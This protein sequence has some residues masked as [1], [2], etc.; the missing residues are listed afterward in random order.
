MLN[1]SNPFNG[2]QAQYKSFTMQLN[3]TFNPLPAGYTG[4]NADNAKITYVASYLFGSAKDWFQPHV[5]ETTIPISFPTWTEFIAALGATF[6]DLDAYQIAFNSISTLKQQRDC[7]SYYATFMSLA[8]VLNI[9]QRTKISFFK[10][11]L[12]AELKNA[13]SYQITLPTGF[14]EFLHVC[15]KIDHQIRANKEACDAILRT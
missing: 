14:E 1:P 8:T 10:K 11:G 9:D 15:I 4:T 6:K 12:H 13:L 2:T 3:L 7:H 5:N